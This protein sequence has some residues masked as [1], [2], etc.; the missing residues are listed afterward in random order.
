MHHIVILISIWIEIVV[1]YVGKEC[2]FNSDCWLSGL[3]DPR[4]ECCLDKNSQGFRGICKMPW[5]FHAPCHRNWQ[6]VK[7]EGE[8]CR[9]WIDGKK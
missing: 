8:I 4:I 1:A 2:H 5:K 3:P 7:K 9:R 6:C